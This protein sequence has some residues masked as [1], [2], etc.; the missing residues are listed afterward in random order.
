MKKCNRCGYEGEEHFQPVMGHDLCPSCY[1][2]WQYIERG[3][4]NQFL[5]TKIK[6]AGERRIIGK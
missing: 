6:M 4:L 3:M 1:V 5:E 2:A